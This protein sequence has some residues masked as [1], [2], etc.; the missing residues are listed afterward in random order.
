M[1]RS[2]LWNLRRRRLLPL[3]RHQQV[4]ISRKSVL[5]WFHIVS[6]LVSCFWRSVSAASSAAAT[7]STA[8]DDA[9]ASACRGILEGM[10]MYGAVAAAGRFRMVSFRKR[11]TNYRALLRKMTY[12][13]KQRHRVC[14]YVCVCVC[15][16][17]WAADDAAAASACRGILKRYLERSSRDI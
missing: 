7:S 12:K 5:Y 3:H 17:V 16:C 1:W 8:A 10:C 9:A 4:R 11:G 14:V 15:L 13:D 2:F 6:W